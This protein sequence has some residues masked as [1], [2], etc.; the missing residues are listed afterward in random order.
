[1]AGGR[2][3]SCF[4]VLK[5]TVL[6]RRAGSECRFRGGGGALDFGVVNGDDVW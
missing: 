5:S 6:D 4:G 3:P 1:M 2:D